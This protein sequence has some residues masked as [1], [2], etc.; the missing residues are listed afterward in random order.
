VSATSTT[1][2]ATTASLSLEDRYTRLD[3]TIYFTGIQALV[4]LVLDRARYDQRR[5]APTASFVS[6]Y[7]G[8]P[9]AGYDLELARRRPLLAQHRIEHRPALNEELAA[10]A[11][12][13]SQLARHVGELRYH[14][15]TG[16]WY[17]K[18]PGLDRATD[19]LRHANLIGSDPRGGAVAIVGDDPAAKSSTVPC[20]SEFALA[21]LAMPTL[22][23]ADPGEVLSLG[24][25]AVEMSRATGLW[26]SLKVPTIV[27]DGACT[28]TVPDWRPPELADPAGETGLYGHRP[29][30]RL[31]GRQLA[32]LE[33]SLHEVRLPAAGEYLRRSD[34]NTIIGRGPARL[35]L[36]AAGSTYLALR[37]ALETLGLADGDL[38]RHGIRLLKLGAIYP[39]D[40]AIVTEFADGLRD[41]VVVEDKRAFIEDAVKSVLYGRPDAPRVA[42][43]R[44]VA[45]AR[46]FPADGELDAAAIAGP[47]SGTLAR[48]DISHAAPDPDRGATSLSL[49]IVSRT[50]FFCSGCPH[51]SSTK[52][53]QGTL[54][55]GGIGCHAMLLLMPGDRAGD[56]TGLSQMGGEG[57][58]WLGMAPFVPQPHYVQNMGD[59]TFAH[60]GSLVVRAAVAAG[61][62]ITFK[63]LRNSAVAMTGGQRPVGEFALTDLIGQLR[64]ERV[65]RIVVTS[66]DTEAVRR[67]VGRAAEVRRRDELLAVQQE[68]AAVPG[69]T[70]LIHDQEC[71]AEKRR[72]RKRGQQTAPAERVLINE[73]V[74]EG[75]GDCGTKSNCLSVHPVQ[76]K[77][78][79]KTQINQ[80]SCNLDFSCLDGDCPSFLTVIP[81][82]G[83][84]QPAAELPAA[85]LPA[86]VVTADPAD[87]TMRITGIGGTGVVTVTQVLATAAAIEGRHVRALDQTGLAQ[88]GGPVVSDLTIGDRPRPRS[89]RL[90]DRSCDLYL[91]CDS[92]VATDPANLRVAAADR[93]IAVMSSAQVPTGEMVTDTSASF[94]ALDRIRAVVDPR[95]RTSRYLDAAGLARS[96]VGD[97]QYANMV[98]VGAA[99][100]AGALPLSWESIQRAIT[101]N[102]TAVEENLAAFRIGREAGTDHGADGSA[103]DGR[104]QPPTD[105]ASIVADHARELADYQDARYARRYRG[106]VDR[107]RDA[108]SRLGADRG[109]AAAV[110]RNL[111]KLMAYKD[112]YEVARLSLDPHLAEEIEARF[113][114]GARF[115]Y[116]LHPPMLRA[117]GMTRKISLGRWFRSVFRLLA[118]MRRLRGTRLDAFGYTRVRRVER[119]L[120]DEYIAAVET[121]TDALTEHNAELAVEIAGL[122]DMV[123]GY[124]HVKLR[125]VEAYHARLAERLTA[126]GG[127]DRAGLAVPSR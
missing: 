19:A 39:L 64:S 118:A 92:L 47:L 33:R 45:G 46:L 95:V 38:A 100:Q 90:S 60:S 72:K 65:A 9:L 50:P 85:E 108:E 49:P 75:C 14:G 112:E 11:V 61:V 36:V 111:F 1:A 123:R 42:G 73:R 53:S 30:A 94:P 31:L 12:S 102:N 10:T 96:R 89:P 54:V 13:G 115:R 20:T 106:V 2:A 27:A 127:G 29:S 81:G 24:M 59:G 23:P 104:P 83:R 79:R 70:V 122:P 32:E 110:A 26:T 16:Y 44:D 5:G 68:L 18:A 6:G 69:V 93:T 74:C 55:G 57:A 41:V 40:P 121:L 107:V 124:E 114:V 97:E 62:N 4:R 101:L 76:T 84:P 117:L 116:R 88:K 48:L 66:D 103:H 3:G 126:F 37:Q 22:V 99:Y 7:E 109:L 67:L 82:R 51:N 80:S 58:Q 52:V 120:V 35:G 125:N 21:D 34:I 71:A 98:L 78:G 86:P 87:F 77:Y 25:H 113:G 43:K 17:G 105:L 8:S 63:L 56:L 119:A 28:A 15:V 91:G